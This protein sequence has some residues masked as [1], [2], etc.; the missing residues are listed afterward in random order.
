MCVTLKLGP[1]L[2]LLQGATKKKTKKNRLKLSERA[3][4]TKA[5]VFKIQNPPLTGNQV[6]NY[7]INIAAAK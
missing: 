2:L 3:N 4:E 7:V 1:P 6:I 5:F